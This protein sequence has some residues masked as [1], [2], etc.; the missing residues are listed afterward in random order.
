MPGARIATTVRG[1]GKADNLKARKWV[2]GAVAVALG[3]AFGLPI[4]VRGRHQKMQHA[5]ESYSGR[6]VKLLTGET[7]EIALAEN[8]TTGYRWSLIS[9]AAKALIN[10]TPPESAPET[11]KETPNSACRFVSDSYEAGRAGVAGQ[12]GIHRWQ[13]RAIEAGACSIALEYRRSWEQAKVPERTFRIQVE[14]RK[15]AKDENPTK[16][17]V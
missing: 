8:P 16:P 13:F 15:G 14:I 17:S 1:C 2:F 9:P 3:L 12:G 4:P 5:D 10:A 7:L 6:T 11:A